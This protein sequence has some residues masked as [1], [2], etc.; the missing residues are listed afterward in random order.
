MPL[1]I[2]EELMQFKQSDIWDLVP[3]PVDKTIIGTR[4]LFRN[5]MGENDVITRNKSRLVAKVYNQAKGIDYEDIYAP[6]AYLETIRLLLAFVCCTDFKLYQID[7]K[8]S[9]LNGH[10]NEEVY[11]SQPSGFEDRDNPNHVFTLKREPSMVSKELLEFG[12]SD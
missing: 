6:I 4:W 7:V 5:K 10:I 2:Q 12:M 1:D 11:V 3:C 9:F 8:P